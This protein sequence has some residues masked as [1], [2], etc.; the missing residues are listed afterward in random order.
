MKYLVF[1][2]AV[3]L[4]A[5]PLQA[6]FCDV[7]PEETGNSAHHAMP[8][9][10]EGHDCC[11][12]G[13]GDSDSDCGPGMDCSLCLAGL[14]AL[15]MNLGVQFAWDHAAYSNLAPGPIIPSHTSP[16]FRPPIS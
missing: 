15:P 11:D 10:G 4:S 1:I 13:Q 3:T 7:A 5:Q 2:L 6:G 12:T 16:P 9:E 14:S 8:M